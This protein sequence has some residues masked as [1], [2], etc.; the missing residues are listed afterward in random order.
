MRSP[1]LNM[2]YWPAMCERVFGINMTNLPLASQA[3]IDQG[4]LDTAQDNI[5][6]ANGMEDPWRWASKFRILDGY[7]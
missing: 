5:F 2:T 3:K 1:Y 6:F 7:N 4:G